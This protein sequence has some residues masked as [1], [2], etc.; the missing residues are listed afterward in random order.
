M[1]IALKNRKESFN[2]YESFSDLLFNTL[3]L[4]LVL[5]VG[6][7]LL[8]SSE[9]EKVQ[10]K[11]AEVEQRLADAKERTEKL[12][13][14][15][16]ALDV[17]KKSLQK[18]NDSLAMQQQNITKEIKR[19]TEQFQKEA[20]AAKDA[21]RMAEEQ[22]DQAAKSAEERVSKARNALAAF[23]GMKGKMK[24]VVILLDLSGSMTLT[25]DAVQ[26]FQRV[27]EEIAMLIEQFE[28][29]KFNVVGFGGAGPDGNLIRLESLSSDLIQATPQARKDAQA[30]VASW[31]VD[32]GTPTLAAL[33]AAFACSELDT[34]MIYT[35][36]DPSLPNRSQ[37]AV[38]DYVSSMKSRQVVINCVGIGAYDTSG[39]AFN[40][41]GN[42]A[43]EATMSFVDFLRRLAA[44]NGG[45]YTAR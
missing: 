33:Q 37:Q 41:S 20:Q 13:Q 31:N 1:G 19:Q 30:K 16:A 45:S 27:K 21:A 8:I 24:N 3:V 22:A 44:D 7:I 4:F 15:E 29:E 14:E 18:Q 32:G 12:R 28:F 38:L 26:R 36:G 34:I 42:P 5:I 43:T 9:I 35:D 6:L 11:E 39:G 25:P 10:K 23:I 2:F 40:P 17:R